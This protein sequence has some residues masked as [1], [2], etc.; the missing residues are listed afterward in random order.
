MTGRKSIQ[1][2]VQTER[3]REQALRRAGVTEVVRF[4]FDDVLQRN[5][6]IAEL[7]R[8]GVPTVP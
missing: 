3:N 8:A 4:T 1:E 5:P 7:R 6:L 2:T